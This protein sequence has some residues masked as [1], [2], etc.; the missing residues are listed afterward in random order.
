MRARF[1]QMVDDESEPPEVEDFGFWHDFD[2]VA[3][4]CNALKAFHVLPCAGGWQDQDEEWVDDIKTFF[5]L[6]NCAQ[7]EYDQEREEAQGGKPKRK[8]KSDDDFFEQLI[9]EAEGAPILDIWDVV[10]D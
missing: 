5:A 2:E 3:D 10:K 6:H 7:W 4:A 1:E 8:K 9:K